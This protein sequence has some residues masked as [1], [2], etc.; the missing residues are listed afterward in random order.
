MSTKIEK[1]LVIQ[2]RDQKI[3][4]LARESADIPVRQKQIETRLEAHKEAMR[5]THDELKKRMASAKEL[6]LEVETCKQRITKF[7]EQQLQI[8]SNVEYKALE[9]EIATVQQRIREVEDQELVFMEQLEEIKTTLADR[10]KDLKLEQ[11]RVDEEVKV[12]ASRKD[13]IQAEIAKIQQD[14]DA[15]TKDVDPDWLSRYDRVFKKFKDVAMVPVEHGTCGGCHM[16][17]PPSVVHNAKNNLVMTSCN[18]CNRML[19]W[20]P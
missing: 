12:L 19:Y 9:R 15:M 6:D 18:F 14:R 4:E 1:L 8:K 16:T 17:L 10:E 5:L 20:K 2:D 11:A 13:A 3:N 7:R